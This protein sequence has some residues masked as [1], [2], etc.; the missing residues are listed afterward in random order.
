MLSIFIIVPCSVGVYFMIF[1]AW[2]QK[3]VN[4]E[5]KAVQDSVFMYGALQKG[6]MY[7]VVC[8]SA[9]NKRFNETNK[10]C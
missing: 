8:T 2:A 4:N 6:D 10:I 5:M 9:T 1:P 3:S 7:W